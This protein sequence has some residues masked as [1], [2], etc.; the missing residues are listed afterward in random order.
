MVSVSHRVIIYIWSY[1]A[2][3]YE[4]INRSDH[5][6]SNVMHDC[7]VGSS[8]CRLV[9]ERSRKYYAGGNVKQL[10]IAFVAMS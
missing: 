9:F 2:G 4:N 8:I 10:M 7:T 5:T 6:L 1:V 3:A